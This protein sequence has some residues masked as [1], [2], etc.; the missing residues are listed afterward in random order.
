M[1]KMNLFMRSILKQPSRSRV[2]LVGTPT[3]FTC[4]GSP[5]GYPQIC[6]FTSFHILVK[7]AN[8]LVWIGS[9][10]SLIINS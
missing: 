5:C 2:P 1:E 4:R 7:D 3:Q 9:N 8:N 10:P 6:A